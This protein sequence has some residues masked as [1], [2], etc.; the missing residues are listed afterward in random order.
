[1]SAA[2][3]VA[4]AAL[5]A[6]L[7]GCGFIETFAKQNARRWASGQAVALEVSRDANNQCRVFISGGGVPSFSA[8]IEGCAP[9]ARQ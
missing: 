5:A 6:A 9:E 3:L 2:R 1:M 8:I 7:A 4:A